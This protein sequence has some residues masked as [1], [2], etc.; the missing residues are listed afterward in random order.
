MQILENQKWS[1]DTILKSEPNTD[2]MAGDPS[3]RVLVSHPVTPNTG[4][5]ER[6]EAVAVCL[7]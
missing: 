6:L 3:C 2:R 4:H 5:R 1:D 7:G